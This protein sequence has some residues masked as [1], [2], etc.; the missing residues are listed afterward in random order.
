MDEQAVVIGTFVRLQTLADGT[1]RVVFDV[2]CTL[3][4]L[5]E[6]GLTPGAPVALARIK[7]EA[8]QAQARAATIEEAGFGKHYACLYKSGWWHN[9]RVTGAF[10]I[11]DAKPEE[12]ADAIKR[13]VYDAFGVSSLSDIPPGDF[14][15]MCAGLGIRQTL[16][17]AFYAS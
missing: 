12:R 3:T 8:A 1:P 10:N 9:P 16:P 7:P 5:A 6:L 4:K 17:Q 11:G 2:D 15:E 13:H 14:A